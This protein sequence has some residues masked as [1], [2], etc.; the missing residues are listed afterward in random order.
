MDEA[1][2]EVTTPCPAAEELACL[3][4]GSLAAAERERLLAHVAGCDDCREAWLL[5]SRL[6]WE[7]EPRPRVLAFRSR[8]AAGAL[9]AAL[10]VM[11][12]GGLLLA[13]RPAARPLPSAAAIDLEA[14]PWARLARS[15]LAF[16]APAGER[17]AAWLG[18]HAAALDAG[19]PAEPLR[20]S[21][22]RL[23]LAQGAPLDS[24]SLRRQA[25]GEAGMFDLARRIEA[26]R[27]DLSR[28]ATPEPAR[29][30]DLVGAAAGLALDPAVR[31]A[32]DELGCGGLTG[33]ACRTRLLEQ[34]EALEALLLA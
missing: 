32:L 27:L 29:A 11:A 10:L 8:A 5:A 16:A 28:G 3:A 17:A 30:G 18:V 31:R 15:Q 24:G 26:W 22:D 6:R 14:A 19:A 23:G 25:L 13:R 34:L 12:G 7:S 4:D 1:P 21:L 2:P 20:A 9:A 33:A